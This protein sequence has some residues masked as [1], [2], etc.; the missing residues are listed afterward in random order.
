MIS[1]GF[2]SNIHLCTRAVDFRKCFDGLCGVVRDYLKS[3][4]LDGSVYVFYNR[5]RDRV[6]LLLWDG[7]GFWLFYKRLEMGTFEIPGIAQ[8]GDGVTLSREQLELILSGIDL[9]S[10]RHR[11]RYRRMAA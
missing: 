11:K 1:I 7:D 6:K 9:R 2:P 4:P 5:R 10:V 3:E 8:E